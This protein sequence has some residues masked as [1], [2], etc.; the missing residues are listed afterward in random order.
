MPYCPNGHGEKEKSFCDECGAATVAQPPA[1]APGDSLRIRSPQASATLH[2]HLYGVGGATQSAAPALV[3]CPRCGK[4]NPE[5][6]VFDCQGQCGREHLCLRHFDEEYDVCQE[7]ARALRQEDEKQAAATAATRRELADWRQRAEKA[8]SELAALGQRHQRSETERSAGAERER[9]L[10]EQLAHWQGRAE[11]AEGELPGLRRQAESAQSAREQA[12]KT[13]DAAQ[14]EAARLQK[15]LAEWKKRA[16]SAESELTALRRQLETAR[17]ES[18]RV[19]SELTGWKKRAEAAEAE[20]APIRRRE[21]EEREALEQLSLSTFPLPPFQRSAASTLP[22][23]RIG[24]EAVKIPAG[25]FLYGDNKEKR[26]LDEFWIAKTPVTNEQYKAFVDATKHQ[27]PQHWQNGRI[28][29]GKEKHPVV[30]VSWDDAQAF[31]KWV[32]GRL[33]SEQE[34]EKAARGRDGRTYPWGNQE[35]DKTRCNFGYNVGDTTPVGNYPAGANGLF[36]MAGNVWEWCADWYDSTQKDRVLRGGS[37]S[38]YPSF[39]RAAGRDWDG[40]G[41][42]NDNVGFRLVAPGL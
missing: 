1:N 7:C 40:P 13:R 16:E 32:G 20:L 36:D 28:P 24:I 15:E 37:W 21:A 5:S 42:R 31:C 11:T 22:W 8:E 30:Y 10:A 29:A 35:P 33:P 2:Q 6:E 12:D 41:V 34:W 27:A 39:V 4:R 9:S 38:A 25:E 3:R 14:S 23:Q 18:A 26:R 19:G 17:Q